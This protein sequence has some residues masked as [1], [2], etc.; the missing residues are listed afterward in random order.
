MACFAATPSFPPALGL[1]GSRL[2]V[3][4]W[5][6]IGIVQL[7]SRRALILLPNML[8]EIRSSCGKSLC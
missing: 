7:C 3:L 2:A 5:S 1:R 8:L 4:D 6:G